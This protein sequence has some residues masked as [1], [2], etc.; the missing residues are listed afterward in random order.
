MTSQF[1]QYF[2]PETLDLEVPSI[3]N[4]MTWEQARI[5]NE[6]LS[7][8]NPKTDTN[9]S[10]NH[11]KIDQ[12]PVIYHL[13]SILLLQWSSGVVPR[14]QNG[15]PRCSRGAKMGSPNFE[16]EAPRGTKAPNW[17]TR[18]AKRGWREREDQLLNAHYNLQKQSTV[19]P[20]DL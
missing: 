1:L 10:Q 4:K 8:V 15:H 11:S 17:Q 2:P 9:K 12:N 7:I 19:F 20:N 16:N 14:Y 18:E 3:D 13:D 5:Q 6:F